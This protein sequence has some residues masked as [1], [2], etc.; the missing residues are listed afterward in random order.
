MPE[1][2]QRFSEGT[3]EKTLRNW[4]WR[5]FTGKQGPPWKAS[6]NDREQNNTYEECGKT[7]AERERE[8]KEVS[9]TG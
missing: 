8:S 7:L 5:E 4:Q 9:R 1:I 2:L 3:R 6:A